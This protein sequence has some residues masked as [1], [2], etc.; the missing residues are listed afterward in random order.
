MKSTK[1]DI[2]L[3]ECFMLIPSEI[4]RMLLSRPIQEWDKN[5]PCPP[6]PKKKSH[7]DAYPSMVS[8]H[9]S[10]WQPE[11][12]FSGLD[13]GSRLHDCVRGR[14]PGGG[15]KELGRP[16]LQTEGKNH[17]SRWARPVQGMILTR[18]NQ[19]QTKEGAGPEPRCHCPGLADTT[20]S[21]CQ[22]GLRFPRLEGG[23]G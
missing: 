15:R 21:V 17:A 13:R 3:S 9:L 23:G 11:L 10:T 2:V 12:G 4:P 6:H 20:F 22:T 5:L 16:W 1:N 8:V 14:T 18:L 7:A 19:T